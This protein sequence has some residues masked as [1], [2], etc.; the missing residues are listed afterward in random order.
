MNADRNARIT[1]LYERESENLQRTVAFRVGSA[2]PALIEDA[3]AFAWAQLVRYAD[4]V[5]PDSP[6]AF[7]WLVT[8]AVREG[9]MQVRDATATYDDVPVEAPSPGIDTADLVIARDELALLSQIKESE[10]TALTLF[11]L[12]LTYQD[13]MAATG[14]TYTKVN[15]AIT[16]GRAA[17]RR[18]RGE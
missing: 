1:A 14:W 5:D 2:D 15:R 9:W 7:W 18:L 12:G 4:V 10:R 16:E 11:A 3:C 6:T 8:V 13:I 17:V